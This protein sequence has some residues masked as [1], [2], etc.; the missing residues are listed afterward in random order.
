MEIGDNDGDGIMKDEGLFRSWDWRW[1]SGR[2][3][4]KVAFGF[5]RHGHVEL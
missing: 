3:R 1:N 2:I 5:Q 4:S